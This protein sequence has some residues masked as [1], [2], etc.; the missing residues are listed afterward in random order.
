[1]SQL[2]VSN[3]I[4]LDAT[5]SSLV[6]LLSVNETAGSAASAGMDSQDSESVNSPS[7]LWREATYVSDMYA[8]H[9]VDAGTGKAAIEFKEPCPFITEEDK[10]EG[11]EAAPVGY[12]YRKYSLSETVDI[13]IRCELQAV[14]A[15]CT[16]ENMD[17]F[18]VSVCTVNEW[19]PSSTKWVTEVDKHVGVVL[20]NELRNNACR[21]ARIM[22]KAILAG[23]AKVHIGFVTR[24]SA[25]E[26]VNHVLL[27]TSSQMTQIFA[28]QLQVRERNLWGIADSI[29]QM[30]VPLPEGRYLITK[31]DAAAN[32]TIYS[33]PYEEEAESA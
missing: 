1:V 10:A 20:A 23:S 11:K 7:N 31:Q 3:F 13:V 14:S 9:V 29:F 27:A 26:N 30:I 2:F 17:N 28:T 8:Q 21:M 25:S 18:L 19:N 32:L 24:K 22:A 12:R 15:P 5:E 33:T 6:N 16:A 4:F